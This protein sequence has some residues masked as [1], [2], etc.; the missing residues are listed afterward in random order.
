MCTFMVWMMHCG[1]RAR[2]IA[3]IANLVYCLP[4]GHS[5]SVFINHSVGWNQHIHK[6]L[7]H[8]CFYSLGLSWWRHQM[9]T[10][11]A[12]LVFCAGNSPITV[13][14]PHKGQWRGALMLSLICA[15]TNSWAN[16]RDAGVLRRHGAHYDAIVMSWARPVN[17]MCYIRHW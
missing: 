10:F 13:N 2:C 17:V 6:P 3:G 7:A 15:W 12:L 14:S 9:E 8:E 16:N 4:T 1:I 11:S 5:E